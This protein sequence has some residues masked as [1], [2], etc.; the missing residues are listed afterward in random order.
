MFEPGFLG[1]PI[2]EIEGSLG[3]EVE[4][5]ERGNVRREQERD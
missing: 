4:G 2:G 1:N 3:I 5:E